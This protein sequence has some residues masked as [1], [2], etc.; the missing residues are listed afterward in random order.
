MKLVFIID[1]LPHLDPTHD[2]SVALMEAAVGAGHTVFWTEMHRLRA[3]G[4]QVWAQLQ[5]VTLHPVTLAGD[6]W[7]AADP[8]YEVGPWQEVH[9]ADMDVVWMRPDPPVTTEYL[10]ATYLLD[11]LM[12]TGCRV[13]NRPAGLRNAN[14]KLYALHF[15]EVMPP[16]LVTGDRRVIADFMAEHGQAVLKPL[17]GK[18]G[19]GILLL[20]PG[21][22]NFNSLVELSTQR[23]RTPVMVQAYLPAAQQGDKR[24]VVLDGEPIGA[25]NRVPGSGEFRGNMAAGGAAEATEITAREREICQRLA[26]KLQADGLFFVGLD[27]IGGFLTEVNVTSPT[28]V[29]EID[30]LSGTRLGAVVMARLEAECGSR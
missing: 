22:R 5:P 24:I 29:R 25:V 23:G 21:D 19:E 1:P 10:Y 11:L 12:A 28:G 27:V 7:Q 14:E 18:G 30:R 2:T 16:T 6:R 13:V 9:L 4:G 26:P 15:A 17:G 3:V 8:W 20:V